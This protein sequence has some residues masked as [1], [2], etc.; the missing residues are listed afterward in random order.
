M[1]ADFLRCFA[2]QFILLDLSW[3]QWL[4]PA[5]SGQVVD[6]TH[7]ENGTAGAGMVKNAHDHG[8]CDG[9]QAHLPDPGSTD[10]AAEY[11]YRKD[12]TGP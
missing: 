4:I 7:W 6:G 2:K 5:D 12:E 10:H 11:G 1:A 3:L 9:E 8:C